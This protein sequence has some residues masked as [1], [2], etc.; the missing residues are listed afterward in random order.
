MVKSMQFCNYNFCWL[1]QWFDISVC[2]CIYLFIYNWVAHCLLHNESLGCLMACYIVT[3]C[4]IYDNMLQLWS[5]KLVF[6]EHH[7]FPL[8]KPKQCKCSMASFYCCCRHHHVFVS[9]QKL[10]FK[11]C[12]KKYYIWSL[13][14]LSREHAQMLS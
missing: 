7:F 11:N 5:S 8:F 12:S 14:L 13:I 3:V 6:I 10:T 9:I 2:Y 1:R 4:P